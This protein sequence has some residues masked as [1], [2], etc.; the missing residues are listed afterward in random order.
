MSTILIGVERYKGIITSGIQFL[1]YLLLVVAGIVP[2][3]SYIYQATEVM[4]NDIVAL[5]LHSLERA[6]LVSIVQ[7]SYIKAIMHFT[8]YKSESMVHEFNSNVDE[9]H[10]CA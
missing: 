8:A 3:H 2:F 9:I 4:V 6:M 10:L 7:R 1:F 5:Y